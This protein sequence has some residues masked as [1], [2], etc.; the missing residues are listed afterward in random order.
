MEFKKTISILGTEYS[1]CVVPP[2]DKHLKGEN[3]DLEIAGRCD[4]ILKRIFLSDMSNVEPDHV[5]AVSKETLRHEIIHAYLEESGLSDNALVCDFAWPVNEEMI[6]WF[7]IMAP[8]IYNTF[9]E[10]EII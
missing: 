3:E 7:A 1:I 4:G 8:K 2:D 6:D 5:A 10:L 9:L